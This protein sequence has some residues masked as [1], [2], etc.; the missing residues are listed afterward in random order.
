MTSIVIVGSGFAGIGVAVE[1]TRAG[2]TDVTLLES[3]DRI[4]GVW[5]ENT[6]PGA[7]CD[8][9]SPYYSFSYE[10]HDR[11]PRRFSGQRD[12]HDYL[13]GVVD[14]YGLRSRIRFG[15]TVTGARFD[16]VAARW[17]IDT[18]T[19]PIEADVLVPATGQLSRPAVPDLP[20]AADFAGTAFHS[21]RWDHDCELT[22][23]RV[24]V[25][26]T[27]ASAIQFVP[28]IQ[29]IVDRLT[30]FQRS[31]PHIVPKPDREYRRWHRTR[32][33]QRAERGVFW[34][35]GELGTLGL[36]GNKLVAKAVAAIARRHL[37][38][39][40]PDERLRA[41]LTP[42][43]EIGCKRV[44]FAN[45]YYPAL[46]KPNTH[47]ETEKITAITPGGVRTADGV[48][49]PADVIVYGTG[50][51]TQQFLGPIE[52]T[53][54][55]GRGLA[56]AW[57]EG[58]RAYL[59]ITV[60]GFPNLFLMYG[61]NTNLGS[62]SIIYMLERQARYIRQ[63]VDRISTRPSYVDVR[64]EVE[65]AYDTEIQRR[66]ADSVWTTCANWYRGPGGRVAS[67][68][69]GLVSEYHRRTKTV[70]PDDFRTVEVSR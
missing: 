58:A 32:T 9:P 70:D 23:K 5:R 56:A 67:N 25:I 59:G 33:T 40:V 26:G 13:E 55:D 41:A 15:T 61:P 47:L 52:I 43:H 53:G 4:G 20:G 36:A 48:E 16:E 27:G 54:L 68:W 1:L 8:V 62:G 57:A 50:F 37:R 14:K 45:D 18:S 6:Y 21:A 63:L 38:K 7:G 65:Q 49:H 22:G 31:A 28:R 30:V 19:G 64:P 69:P 24:A 12:I 2:H 11:W 29:P 3:A 34:S 39:Q 51:A 60:P 44:L 17:L 42:D 10:P 35:V 66:L 46:T